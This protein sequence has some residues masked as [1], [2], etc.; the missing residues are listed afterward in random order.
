MLEGGGGGGGEGEGATNEG[1][2]GNGSDYDSKDEG[3]SC[4]T[5]NL[6][7]STVHT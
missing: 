7:L 4:V 1:E 5:S 3:L 6:P 2:Q